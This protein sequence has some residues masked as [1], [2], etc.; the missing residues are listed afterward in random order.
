MAG[1]T[2]MS[3]RI[4]MARKQRESKPR[5]KTKSLQKVSWA[6]VREHSQCNLDVLFSI[7]GTC[8]RCAA[9]DQRIDDSIVW[10]VLH[11]LILEDPPSTLP[12][13]WLY[14]EILAARELGR[15]IDEETWNECLRMVRDSVDRHSAHRPGDFSYLAYIKTATAG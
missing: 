14:S 7:E 5:P 3:H 11:A 10:S 15:D 8:T 2:R 13:A 4:E 1:A 9:E 6:K 12:H